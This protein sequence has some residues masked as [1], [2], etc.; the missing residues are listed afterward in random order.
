MDEVDNEGVVNALEAIVQSFH[1]EIVPYS[2]QLIQ[3][4]TMAFQKYCLKQQKQMEQNDEEYDDYGET[5]LTAASCLEAIKR[6]L[7]SPLPEY[8]YR[9][10]ESTL[11]PVLNYILSNEGMDYID[12]G[13]NILN[14]LL[15]N[16]LTIS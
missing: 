12:E 15:F 14:L 11:I 10:L 4:L 7:W 8:V 3:H 2:Y 5:E 1:N 9:K 16:Q 6:I 13:L